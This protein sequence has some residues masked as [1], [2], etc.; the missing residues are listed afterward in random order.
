MTAA[1]TSVGLAS[2][3]PPWVGSIRVRLTV[4]YA[5]LVFGLSALLTGGVYLGLTR[6]LS[7]EPVSRTYDVTLVVPT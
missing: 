6:S 3:L 4:L 1:T 5:V 7:D 2:R